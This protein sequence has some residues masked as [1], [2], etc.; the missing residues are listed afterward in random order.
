M[1]AS[2]V[3]ASFSSSTVRA[4]FARV[5]ELGGDL[6]VAELRSEHVLVP[7]QRAHAHQIDQPGEV[8][9][10]ADG[11]LDGHR[12]RPE[13]R[14]HL[15]HHLLEARP[16]PV[17]LVDERDAGHIV[18]VGLLPDRLALGLHAFDGGENPDCSV[19]HS[20][21]TF[22]L[23][24]EV[25]VSRR[26]DDIHLHA[27]PF[28]EGRG[29]RYGDAALLLKIHPVHL[30]FAIMDLADL[31]RPAGIVQ[32]AFCRRRLTGVNMGHDPNIAYRRQGKPRFHKVSRCPLY[33]R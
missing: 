26:V 30:G 23:D 2:S 25:D 5:R 7:D 4:A 17:H 9:L 32:N 1:M 14:V 31:V 16:H 33:Q 8:R 20:Q 27:A 24:R 11:E 15:L 29:S 6:D 28:A 18:A 13:L 19:Q 21:R 12:V 10:V 22:H 3:S